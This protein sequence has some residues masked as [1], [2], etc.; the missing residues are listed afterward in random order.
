[1]L[2]KVSMNWKPLAE[3][4]VQTVTKPDAVLLFE[5]ASGAVL[6]AWVARLAAE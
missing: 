6:L 5:L 4:L 2:C 1:M 3:R